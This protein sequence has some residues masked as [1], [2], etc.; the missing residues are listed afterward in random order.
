VIGPGEGS[1]DRIYV[2][3]TV[4]ASPRSPRDTSSDWGDLDETHKSS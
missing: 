2:D 4:L 1:M 3:A